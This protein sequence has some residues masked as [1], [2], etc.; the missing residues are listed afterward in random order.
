VKAVIA[1][2]FL[3]ITACGRSVAPVEAPDPS[4]SPANMRQIVTNRPTIDVICDTVT[5][6][7]IYVSDNNYNL[8]V[9]KDGCSKGG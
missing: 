2:A 7:L 9:V 1:A 4:P 6:N 5:G 8:A 3:A